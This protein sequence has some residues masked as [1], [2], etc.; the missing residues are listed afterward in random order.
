MDIE[1]N[2]KKLN[3]DLLVTNISV[4]ALTV[5]VGILAVKTA[6]TTNCLTEAVSAV[7]QKTSVEFN[8]KTNTLFGIWQ[9]LTPKK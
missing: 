6:N 1:K 9:K 7:S 5:I 8:V 4:L 2:I 3:R